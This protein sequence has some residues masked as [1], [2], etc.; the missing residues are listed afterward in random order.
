MLSLHDGRFMSQA[1]LASHT[2]VVRGSSR[3]QRA[4]R[5][6]AHKAWLMRLSCI[7]ARAWQLNARA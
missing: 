1:G 3:V 4:S 6:E 5:G 2:D 7:L